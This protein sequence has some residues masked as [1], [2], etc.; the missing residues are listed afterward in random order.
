MGFGE[1]AYVAR[2]LLDAARWI[3]ALGPQ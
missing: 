1:A 3:L 2:D